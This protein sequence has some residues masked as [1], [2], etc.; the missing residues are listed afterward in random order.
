MQFGLLLHPA[1]Q[2][3]KPLAEGFVRVSIMKKAHQIGCFWVALP[4]TTLPITSLC[5]WKWHSGFS[6]FLHLKSLSPSSPIS[7]FIQYK[8][9]D[10]TLN[11]LQLTKI[12]SALIYTWSQKSLVVMSSSPSGL[13]RIGGPK[14]VLQRS[15]NSAHDGSPREHSRWAYQWWLSPSILNVAS[16]PHL[17]SFL[18]LLATKEHLAAIK[19]W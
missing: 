17:V 6:S 16:L 3:I 12:V 11:I 5:W 13:L 7:Q 15:Q 4:V 10:S 9:K 18:R 14:R 2:N 19:P 1:Y 8:I